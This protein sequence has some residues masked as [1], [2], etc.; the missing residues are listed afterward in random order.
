VSPSSTD[1][2]DYY[3]VN[4]AGSTNNNLFAIVGSSLFTAAVFTYDSQQSS[5]NQFSIRV[6]A[7]NKYDLTYEKALT[8]TVTQ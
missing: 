6:Q 5:S 4:G 2:F 8:V 1:R 7:R 3:L